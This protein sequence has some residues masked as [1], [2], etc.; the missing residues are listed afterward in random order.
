[1]ALRVAV[2]ALGV[3]SNILL[4][5][6]LGPFGKGVYAYVL[7]LMELVA[8]PGAGLTSAVSRQYGK[9]ALPREAVLRAALRIWLA[10][11]ASLVGG[12][13]IFASLFPAQRPLWALAVAI[14]CGL[15]GQIS[16]G[17]FL[18]DSRVR[19]VNTQVLIVNAGSAVAI[20][21]LVALH[22]IDLAAALGVWAAAYVLSALY[23][24]H[25]L[26][27]APERPAPESPE[28][29]SGALI[30]EQLRFAGRVSAGNIAALLNARIDLFLLLALSG[31]RAAGVYSVALGIAE[32][33]WQLGKAL[34]LTTYGRVATAGDCEAAALTAKCSRYAIAFV[35][36]GALAVAPLA[37]PAVSLVY[38]P[39]FASAGPAVQM[40][41]PG[42]IAFAAQPLIGN[43]FVQ[44]RGEPGVPLA[45]NLL[46]SVVC[47]AV[48][49]VTIPRFGIAGAAAATSASYILSFAVAGLWFVRSSNV[50]LRRL[51][52]LNRADIAEA[53]T[54]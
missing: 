1:M 32:L 2:Q 17:V 39:A 23:S 15:F 47:A 21:A 20:V 30:R 13:A 26:R 42:M 8:E 9:L 52:F 4:A 6:A 54:W 38:G 29:R 22:R 10:V 40:L 31:P 49:L 34:A 45:V 33:L 25:V 37:T 18:A 27:A 51:V 11:A 5:R 24:I 41:L 35:A 16:S 53:L 44:Q 46:S 50:P 48:S 19:T 7:S 12:I 36:L 3:G 14:P 43:Y 28:S